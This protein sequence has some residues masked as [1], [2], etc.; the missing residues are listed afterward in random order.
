MLFRVAVAMAV[1]ARGNVSQTKIMEAS[2]PEFGQALLAAVEESTFTP[3]LKDGQP[4]Q[5]AIR[6]EHDF[7]PS[8]RDI[9]TNDDDRAMLSLIAKHPERIVPADTLDKPIKPTLARKPLIPSLHRIS[10][11][12]GTATV[13][14][15]IDQDGKVL[16]PQIIAASAPEFGYAAVQAVKQWTFIHPTVGGKP[17]NVRVRIPLEF[18]MPEKPKG[19]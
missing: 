6:R 12:Q 16:L 3:A 10:G 9:L 7:H 19:N 13:E 2:S 17:V 4:I 18:N 11:T 15:I 5:S 14:M 1:D 8:G